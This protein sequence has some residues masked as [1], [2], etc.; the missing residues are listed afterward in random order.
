M[1]PRAE[2][3][4]RNA[5]A[6]RFPCRSRKYGTHRPGK[7]SFRGKA[8]RAAYSC[9]RRIWS[10][11]APRCAGVRLETSRPRS[12]ASTES[13]WSRSRVVS[14]A[15]KPSG[16]D[17]T[18]GTIAQPIAIRPKR[19]DREDGRDRIRDTGR[20]SPAERQYWPFAL[21]R[22]VRGPPNLRPLRHRPP[23]PPRRH[24]LDAEHAAVLHHHGVV[25]V[26]DRGAHVPRHQPEQLAARGERRALGEVDREVLLARMAGDPVG[27]THHGA[28]GLAGVRR[29][30]LVPPAAG[31]PGGGGM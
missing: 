4:I 13:K 7:S 21:P 1:S 9:S 18:G 25:E 23:P 2:A 29:H 8:P 10:A 17:G 30:R 22:K 14:R 6:Q 3:A 5:M 20:S 31:E 11:R 26:V 12:S 28:G 15:A 24:R 19:M 16:S 27:V